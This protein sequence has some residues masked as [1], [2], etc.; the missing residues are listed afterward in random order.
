MKN[1][2][3]F[4]FAGRCLS[5]DQNPEF[6]KRIAS[7]LENPDFNWVQFV[8]LCSNHLVLPSI[9]LKFKTHDIIQ[10]LPEEVASHLKEIYGLNFARNQKILLQIEKISE[11]LNKKDIYPIYLKG[12]GNLIDNVYSSI[13]DRILGDID[14][15]VPED[16]YLTAANLLKDEGYLEVNPPR[17]YRVVENMKHYP[18][19]Y[20]PEFPAVIEVHRIPVYEKYLDELNYEKINSQMHSVS[21][22]AGSYTLSDKHKIIL[23]FVHSQFG[24]EDR[25]YS[26][27]SLRDFYDLSLLSRRIDFRDVLP[28]IRRKSEAKMYFV[29]S[30]KLMGLTEP[31][32]RFNKLKIKLFT[33]KQQTL[34]DSRLFYKTYRTTYFLLQMIFS[35]Y[36][37]KSIKLFYS[38][39][40]RSEIFRKIKNP[41]W[42]RHHLQ[43][44][45]KS[46]KRK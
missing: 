10:F 7:K 8:A 36:I 12:A 1:S 30:C 16:Q 37:L 27:A 9:F 46:L 26:I 3:M 40:V 24:N 17:N 34:L 6:K 41:S 5:L 20:H 4:Y 22:F 13:G 23:N 39:D 32:I 11:V 45:I 38:P 15:L 31:D 29:F 44:Y 14:F 21:N 35:H 19:M 18:R 25:T 33:L 2:E 42:Y 28:D 43:W